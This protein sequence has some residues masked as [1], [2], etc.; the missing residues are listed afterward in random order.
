MA[1]RIGNVFFDL[2]KITGVIIG[3]GKN[4]DSASSVSVIRYFMRCMSLILYHEIPAS[5]I[6]SKIIALKTRDNLT[7]SLIPPPKNMLTTLIGKQP[8]KDRVKTKK[9]G[10]LSLFFLFFTVCFARKELTRRAAAGPASKE[11][12]GGKEFQRRSSNCG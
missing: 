4:G 9:I 2:F 8:L 12:G 10:K 1:A 5:T 11:E 7:D 6:K 3:N